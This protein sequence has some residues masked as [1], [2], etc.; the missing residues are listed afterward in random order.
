MTDD[1]AILLG[2]PRQETRNIDQ[3]HQGDV[4]RVTEPHKPGT[5][6]GGINIEHPRKDH[7]LVRDK[8]H[9]AP[10]DPPK[11][12]HQ[13]RREPRMNLQ[14][15]TWSTSLTMMS[16]TSLINIALYVWSD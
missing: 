11:P 4:E 14:E 13:V 8:P 12:H 9:R 3:G 5:L 15:Y 16:R 1:P 7:R 6:I 10:R 2:D